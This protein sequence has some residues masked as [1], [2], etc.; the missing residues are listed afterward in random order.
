MTSTLRKSFA[1]VLCLAA[2]TV[3]APA[4]DIPGAVLTASCFTCHGAAGKSPGEIPG[5]AGLD[6]TD[7]AATLARYRAGD[8]DATIMSRIAKGYTEAE[9][10]A[11]VA[12]LSAQ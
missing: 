2:G 8:P 11:V 10:A 9:I 4:A 6:A 3:A 7:L 1:A 12:Y 5:I